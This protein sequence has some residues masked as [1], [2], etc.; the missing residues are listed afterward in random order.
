MSFFKIITEGFFS[1]FFKSHKEVRKNYE[2]ICKENYYYTAEEMPIIKVFKEED[3]S[4]YKKVKYFAEFKD[5]RIGE[6]GIY[7][8]PIDLEYWLKKYVKNGCYKVNKYTLEVSLIPK[9]EEIF[10]C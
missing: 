9:K 4:I 2:K 5:G 8:Y 10:S 6:I 1:F 7:Y 3:F